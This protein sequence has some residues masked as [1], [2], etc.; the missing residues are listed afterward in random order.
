MK[1]SHATKIKS[2]WLHIERILFEFKFEDQRVESQS[3]YP[4]R[5]VI[6]VEQALTTMEKSMYVRD[7]SFGTE[8]VENKD[9]FFGISIGEG[10]C[11]T[12]PRHGVVIYCIG[13]YFHFVEHMAFK[14]WSGE[15][16][17]L[18][19]YRTEVELWK[20]GYFEMLG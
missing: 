2:L 8:S 7:Q 12:C 3:V 5:S 1:I 14:V 6:M 11:D 10:G 15:P 17:I 16:Y 9:R 13:E 18:N 20:N 4:Y 19:P